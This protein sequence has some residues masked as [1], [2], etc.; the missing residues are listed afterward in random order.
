MLSPE[1]LTSLVECSRYTSWNSLSAVS[2]DICWVL[3]TQDGFPAYFGRGKMDEERPFLF[4]LLFIICWNGYCIPSL[5]FMS[6]I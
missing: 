5:L 6:L 4:F 2:Q 1:G 3:G